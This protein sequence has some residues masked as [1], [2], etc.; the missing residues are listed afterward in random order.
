MKK[1]TILIFAIF[2]TFIF[3]S[4]EEKLLNVEPYGSYSLSNLTS[5][6]AIN[7]L[8]I[9]CYSKLNGEGITH[10]DLFN[11]AGQ[12]VFGSLHAGDVM[13]GGPSKGDLS[14]F[15]E[16]N[17]FK[18][19]PG[20]AYLLDAWLCWWDAIYRCNLVLNQIDKITGLSDAKKLELRAETRFLR[21]HYYF[22]LKRVY[23]NIPW[24]DETTTEIRQPNTVNNDGVTF[25]DVWPQITADFEFAKTNLAATQTD[26]GRPNKWAAACYYAK[27]MIWR[28][29]FG[30]IT[31][32]YSKALVVLNDVMANGITSKGDRYGLQ[33]NYYRNFSAV[34]ENSLESVWAVQHSVNDGVTY[35]GGALGASV[36]GNQEARLF[37]TM[38]ADGPGFANGWGFAQPSQFFVDQFRTSGKGLPYLD[39]YATNSNSIISDYGKSFS[40]PFTPDTVGVD[41]RLDWTVGRR[42]IPFLDYGIMPGSSWIRGPEVGGPYVYKKFNIKKSELG[43]YVKDNK[44]VNNA[45]NVDIIRYADVLLLAAECEAR[46]GSL[47]NARNLVNQVRNRMILNSTSVDNW[48]KKADN[49]NAANYRIKLYPADGSADDA[50]TTPAKALQAIL[51]ERSIELGLEGHKFWDILRF[52]VDETYFNAWAA[53]M[54]TALPG[55]AINT[56]VYTRVPDAYSPIPT[57]AIDNSLLNGVSTITQ[58]PGY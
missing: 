35:S 51:F 11:T 17:E 48:V 56:Y 57:T 9:G 24:I 38:N 2:A 13:K 50:F 8:L 54:N 43:I 30:N 18:I 39:Y 23:N 10:K 36:R 19:T 16:Y 41:P 40:S 32:G 12:L 58:N 34:Y 28:Q 4:C 26:L 27:I 52:G 20:N 42:G 3:N 31:D 29:N 44:N 55:Q 22:L 49:T 5:E 33:S 7:K 21:G 45:I 14:Q 1:V 37:T 15:Q 47:T 53:K 46:I 6:D 25:V